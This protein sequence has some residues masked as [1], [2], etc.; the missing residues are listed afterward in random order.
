[1]VADDEDVDVL[2]GCVSAWVIEWQLVEFGDHG[3]SD[4][5]LMI[6]ARL[7]PLDLTMSCRTVMGSMVEVCFQS[8][9][10]MAAIS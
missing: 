5:S 9:R 4:S 7:C 3:C 8:P 1:M 6:L 2:D 10:R